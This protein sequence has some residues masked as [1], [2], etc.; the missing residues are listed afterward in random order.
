MS[1]SVLQ[2]RFL[3][4]S[5]AFHALFTELDAF[6]DPE[7]TLSQFCA[8]IL[9][10]EVVFLLD[11]PW[12]DILDDVHEVASL[13]KAAASEREFMSASRIVGE[14]PILRFL[15]CFGKNTICLK[16]L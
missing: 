9:I 7:P 3:G 4:I 10:T 13:V 6:L 14:F 11:P 8:Q 16:S 15:E 5:I 2:R 12:R 1:P